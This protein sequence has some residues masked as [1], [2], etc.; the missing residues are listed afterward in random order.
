M[1][2]LQEIYKDD[3]WKMLVC[4]I[5]LNLTHRRQVDK[6]RVK[7]FDRYPTPIHMAFSDEEELS[8]MLTPLGFYNKRAITLKR[9]SLEYLRGFNDVGDLYGVGKYAEDSW[10]IFQNENYKIEPEDKVLKKY[11]DNRGS[12]AVF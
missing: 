1:D 9:M 12:R 6:V 2:L 10:E 5:L 3:P 4:C 11:L 8:T 7:L